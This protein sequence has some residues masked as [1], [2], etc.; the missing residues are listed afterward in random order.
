MFEVAYR[1]RMPLYKLVEEMPYEEYVGWTHF[2][3]R[4]TTEWRS[5]YRTLLLMQ[6]FGF[7]GKGENVFSSL[8]K[9]NA[10]ANAKINSSSAI[11]PFLMKA[12]GGDKI[13]V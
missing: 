5:D 8:K 13:N 4:E 2:F 12:V 9:L 3:S 11:M 7:T 10:R 6:T 1:L